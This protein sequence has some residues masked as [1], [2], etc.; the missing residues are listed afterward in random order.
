MDISRVKY[1]LGKDVRLKLPRHYVDGKYKL[2][3][4][5]LRRKNNGEFFY[6][7]EL[8]DKTSG[9]VAITSLEDISEIGRDE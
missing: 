3:G 9:S 8:I 2:T 1:N 5:I 6:Q 4:C 7:A